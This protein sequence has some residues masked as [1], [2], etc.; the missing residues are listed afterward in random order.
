MEQNDQRNALLAVGLAFL[1][2]M[3]YQ[4]FYLAPQQQRARQAE[5]ARREQM[6]A[7]AEKAGAT[8]VAAIPAAPRP[9]DA[10]VTEEMAAG[11]RISL[12]APA[13]GGSVAL[14]GG[15]IDDV[16]LHGFYDNLADKRTQNKNAEVQLLAPA[17][18]DQ[19]F[20]ATLNWVGPTGQADPRLPAE[21][22]LWTRIGDG[23]LTP[24]SPLKL[25]WSS[26]GV[27]VERTIA[28]D[29]GFMFTITDKLI[30]NGVA[31]LSVK[32]VAVLRQRQTPDLLKPAPQAHQGVIGVYDAKKNQK[33]SYKELAKNKGVEVGA[34]AG[35]IGL[36]TKYWMAAAIPDQAKPVTFLASNNI[37]ATGSI[38]QAGYVGQTVELPP[39][40]STTETTRIFAGAKQVDTLDAYQKSGIPNFTDAVDWSWLWF[41]TKPFFWML[42]AF[43]KWA[44]SFGI[45]LLLSTLVVKT[46]FFPIQ[47]KMYESMSKMRKLQPQMQELQARFKEDRVKLQQEMMGLYQREKVN[48]LSG[49]LP[50]IPQ[51]FVFYALYHVLVVTLE[52]RHAPFFGWIQDMSAPDPTTIFNL[53][54]LLPFDPGAIPLIGPFLMIGVWPLLYGATM[55]LLQGMSPPP[56]D[57]TQKMIM[58]WLP[59]IF[60]ILF[61]GVAAGLAI[62]WTWSN[63]IT[64]VQQYIIMRRQGVETE[65][66]KLIKKHLSK[67]KP[68]S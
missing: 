35:W 19:A 40:A 66:D 32:P 34:Q 14:V 30:N 24:A 68:A 43:Q 33:R 12:D 56:T 51:M 45:A 64:L 21:N 29:D 42:N 5:I 13:V 26:D 1:F 62:Y 58:Q 54:G 25:T 47:W 23:P 27:A 20:Y 52:M 59:V 48:P 8:G 39:G 38:F 18:A 16:S 65:F 55:F 3:L 11:Q 37:Q 67:P 6:Q 61:A 50:I 36:T 44:G 60:L 15:L 22:S 17:S 49:C 28:I 4:A 63:L 2:F 9:R 10:I 57:P 46:I 7:E 53:F 41:I 31:P